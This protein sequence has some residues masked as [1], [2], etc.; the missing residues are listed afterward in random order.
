MDDGDYDDERKYIRTLHKKCEIPS[1]QQRYCFLILEGC[2]PTI[3]FIINTEYL[4][5]F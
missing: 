1:K 3:I 4:K 2:F 5:I